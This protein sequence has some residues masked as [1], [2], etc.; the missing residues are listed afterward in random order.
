MV[1]DQGSLTQLMILVKLFDHVDKPVGIANSIGITVQGVNYHLKLMKKR[2][3][4]TDENE[5]S[6]EGVNFLESGLNSL[7]DFVSDNLTKID[8]IVTWEAIADTVISKG[9]VVGIYMKDGYLHAGPSGSQPTGI[10]KNSA[11]IGEVVGVSSISSIIGIELGSIEIFVL[12]PVE[13]IEDKIS[14]LKKL[15][16]AFNGTHVTAVSGEQAYVMLMELG[17]KPEMEYASINGVFEAATRGLNASLLIS[18]RRFHYM[19]S[20]LKELQNRFKEI[21][22]RINYL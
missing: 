17:V 13:D 21:S 18:S 6:K 14:L 8:N 19:L 16:E 10:S 11:A 22:V 7:R 3:L 4:I 5:L 2:G 12:P 15:Q 20:D 9:D 1:L